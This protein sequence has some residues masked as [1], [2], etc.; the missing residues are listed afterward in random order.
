MA[1][2]ET[3]SPATTG[4][5]RSFGRIFGVL[6]SPQPTFESI[7]RRPTWLLPIILLVCVGVA[8]T[9]VVTH[10]VGWR[11]VID[12]EIESNPKAQKR[13]EQL[14]P[15]K[16]DDLLNT[17]AKF[18]PYV[19]YAINVLFPF[20]VAVAAGAIFLA[21]F[22][23]GVGAKITLKTS[24]A[25]F[26]YAWVPASIAGLLGILVLFLKDPSTVDVK[27]LVASNPGALMSD[28]SPKW[29]VTLLTSLDLFSFWTL[30]LMAIGY[31]AADPKKISFGMA[32][33]AVVS[34]WIVFVIIKV[35]WV[36]AFS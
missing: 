14:P 2:A 29:L 36:A 3:P 1:S 9:T 13:L 18:T 30:I 25:V 10:R 8:V 15:E 17:Q 35:G 31:R 7:V 23:L 33:G 6:F 4:S 21:V 20:I 32:L 26:A 12:R 5:D 34:V 19:I 16:R 22:N 24:M 27:N 28:D 11:T